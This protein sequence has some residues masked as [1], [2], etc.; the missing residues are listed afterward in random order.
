MHCVVQ[1]W[2]KGQQSLLWQGVLVQQTWYTVFAV[3]L[4]MHGMLASQDSVPGPH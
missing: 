1:S 2:Q 3:L 4:W